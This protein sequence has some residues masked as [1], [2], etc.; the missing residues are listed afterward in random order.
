STLSFAYVRIWL[1]L[2]KQFMTNDTLIM[3][4]FGA[5]LSKAEL[6]LRKEGVGFSYYEWPCLPRFFLRLPLLLLLRKIKIAAT[7]PIKKKSVTEVRSNAS[8]P[9]SV[10][11][12]KDFSVHLSDSVARK[13]TTPSISP[14]DF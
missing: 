3:I 6:C 1:F 7:I 8:S 14:A 2:F 4:F 5:L 13:S 11:H 10:R 12:A 9:Q